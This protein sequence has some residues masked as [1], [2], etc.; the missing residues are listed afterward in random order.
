MGL[1]ARINDVFM[2]RLRADRA[3]EASA[4]SAAF[5]ESIPDTTRL[6]ALLYPGFI[7]ETMLLLAELSDG[8]L[9]SIDE[10]D[11]HW[12]EALALLDREGR[13]VLTSACWTLALCGVETRTPI[14]L[15]KT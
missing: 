14:E 15:Y 11:G 6:A 7:G 2:R 3:R 4:R 8:Q 5:I 10:T 1:V 13:T 9:R 12:H